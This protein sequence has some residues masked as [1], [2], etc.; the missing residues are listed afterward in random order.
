MSKHSSVPRVFLCSGADDDDIE[1]YWPIDGKVFLLCIGEKILYAR[2]ISADRDNEF[3]K[4]DASQLLLAER[5]DRLQ[6][7]R[8]ASGAISIDATGSID[9]VVAEILGMCV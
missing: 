2:L 7:R 9:E 8:I 6:K 4:D 5:H 1:Q 3:A